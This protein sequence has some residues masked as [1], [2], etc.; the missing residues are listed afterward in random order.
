MAKAGG[1]KGGKGGGGG[2]GGGGAKGKGKEKEMTDEERLKKGLL[3][4]GE[5]P[6]VESLEEEMEQFFNRFIIELSSVRPGNYG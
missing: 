6:D 3:A 4:A 1:N 5:I 2:G